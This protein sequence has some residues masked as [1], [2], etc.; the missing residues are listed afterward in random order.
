MSPCQQR[1][2]LSV[3]TPLPFP[4]RHVTKCHPVFTVE[5]GSFLLLCPF[6]SLPSADLVTVVWT[7]SLATSLPHLLRE[8]RSFSLCYTTRRRLED[9]SA[10]PFFHMSFSSSFKARREQHFTVLLACDEKFRNESLSFQRNTEQTSERQLVGKIG[11]HYE[12]AQTFNCMGHLRWLHSIK[13]MRRLLESDNWRF[14]RPSHYHTSINKLVAAVGVI[15]GHY[16]WL[17][18]FNWLT[19]ITELSSA[20]VT[21]L[22]LSTAVAT[23]CWCSWDKNGKTWPTIADS[24]LTI[25][26]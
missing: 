25:S 5:V 22:A 26:V 16:Y 4:S 24:L 1:S 9:H 6:S 18:I 12:I 10:F 21:C 23:C 11:S 17:S 3:Q 2:E 19:P 14:C 13:K 8:T 7:T 20:M 15:W